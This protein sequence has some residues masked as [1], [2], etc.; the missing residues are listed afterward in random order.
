[1]KTLI[2][3]PCTDMMHVGFV[4]SLLHLE[5]GDSTS[6]LFNANSL[7]YDSRNLIALTAIEKKFDRVLW[8]DSDMMFTPA[9]MKML[10]EDL[11]AN[12]ECDMVT[13]LYFKRR[14]PHLPVIYQVLEEPRRDDEGHMIGR[15]RDYVDYPKDKLFPV[16]GCGF[17]CCMT[18]TKLLKDVWDNFGPAFVPYVWAGEDISF[19]HRVNQLGYQIMCDS[20]VTC[21]HIGTYVYTEENLTKRGDVH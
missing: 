16:R 2:A 5:K 4:Q 12:P 18:T 21:G 6:V 15:I 9:T 10:A 3:I 7:I 8:L 1:M 19:C 13:G 11:D 17:G 14:A 20:R